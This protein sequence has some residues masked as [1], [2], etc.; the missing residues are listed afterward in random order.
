MT[1]YYYHPVTAACLSLPP[2]L[3]KPPHIFTAPLQL[4]QKTQTDIFN[5]E[6]TDLCMLCRTLTEIILKTRNI[7]TR[8]T[9]YVEENNLHDPFALGVISVKLFV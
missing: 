1:H 2:Q 6:N 3:I 8:L 7:K 4:M 5:V 9:N